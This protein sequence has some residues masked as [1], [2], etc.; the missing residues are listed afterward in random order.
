MGLTNVLATANSGL[1]V[2]QQGLNVVARNI[3]NADAPGYTRKSLGQ[4]QQ[5][6]DTLGLGAKSIGVTRSVNA[7]L[8]T[9]IRAATSDFAA[10]DVR[11]QFLS[12]ID[13]MF[14]APG[15]Q[16]GLDTIL[17]Q[18]QQ[19]LQALSI[20][21]DS[22]AAREAVVTDAEVLAQSLRQLSGEVQQ[23]R[24]LAEDS[25]AQSVDVINDSLRQLARINQQ[26][27]L[28]SASEVP[29]ADLLDERDKFLDLIAEQLDIRVTETA[30]G[31]VSVF[32][33]S[34]NALL[35][36]E[37]VTLSF[38]HHGDIRATSL[39]DTDPSLRGVGTVTLHATNG[40]GID[41]I[42][43]G[44]LASGRIGALFELRDQTLTQTQAQLDELA[45]AL[46]LTFSRKSV[47]GV[48]VS[49]G[50]QS[51]FEIDTS[52]L[53]PGNA[54]TLT[55]TATPPGTARTVTIVRV[56]DPSKLP[57]A[58]SV[59]ADPTD[60]VLG[61]DFSG[62]PAAAAAAIQAALGPGFTVSNPGGSLLRILDDGAGATTD[63]DG[64]SAVVTASASQDDGLQLPVFV[65]VGGR[66]YS[67]SLDVRDQKIGFAGRISINAALQQ[68]N[69][70]LVRYASSP[71]T[72]LGDAARPLDLLAR[73]AENEFTFS[74]ASGIGRG[75]GPY[76]GS[77]VG[78][79]GRV[80]NFQS[81][82]ADQAAR[83]KSSRDIVLTGLQER[84]DRES[85]VDIDQELSQ[86]ITL[87][88]AFAANA[89]VIQ[90]ANELMRLLFQI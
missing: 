61:V 83:Q 81:T 47:D 66:D 68:N 55:Y 82:Q 39:Y 5:T 12:Q 37:S 80:I 18:F 70:L 88:N 19:S 14:G 72:P 71:A 38:D 45:H 6:A 67:A 48:A 60:S 1:R 8:Q 89:R 54:I 44:V 34:G 7:Y 53:L 24:Q 78:F 15:A 28:I 20:S 35:Q 21:P 65:D 79:A 76:R 41:L 17:S 90:V 52:G 77:V 4:T 26:L 16:N 51:G 25:I 58:D 22:F 10:A 23:L 2:T 46:A 30:G 33:A 40:Y 13:S 9:Q 74:P 32:T 43:N 87:Q 64:L 57:L 62:G 85:G 73:L 59:T 63:V 84:F 69:E 42:N 27:G 50:A 3:A 56:D 11:A 86:L 75:D 29:P 36:G 31:G 49:D